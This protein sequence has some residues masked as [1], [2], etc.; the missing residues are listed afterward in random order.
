M[1]DT[2]KGL[3]YLLV[4]VGFKSMYHYYFIRKYRKRY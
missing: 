4:S 3:N 2:I 1:F